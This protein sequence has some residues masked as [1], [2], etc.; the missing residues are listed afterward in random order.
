MHALLMCIL[1]PT[2]KEVAEA[3]AEIERK[4]LVGVD[5][6]T[7]S[8]GLTVTGGLQSESLLNTTTVFN[9]NE[10]LFSYKSV[11]VSPKAHFTVHGRK[12]K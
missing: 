2:Q 1:L 5:V 9:E 3:M 10:K 7:C 4:H 12:L 11:L 8:G 6:C